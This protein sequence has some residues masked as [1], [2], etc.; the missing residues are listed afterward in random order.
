MSLSFSSER[1][2]F[3]G[4]VRVDAAAGLLEWVRKHPLGEADLGDSK[5]LHAALLQLLLKSGIRIAAWPQEPN[6]KQW[7]YQCLGSAEHNNKERTDDPY[8]TDRR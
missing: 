8:D 4:V 2:T 1:A 7:L 6:L 3:S 5:H